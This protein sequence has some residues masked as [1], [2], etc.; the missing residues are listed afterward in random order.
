MQTYE[1]NDINK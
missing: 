1:P